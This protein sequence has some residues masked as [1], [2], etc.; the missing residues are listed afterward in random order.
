MTRSAW[1]FVGLLALGAIT[2]S[3]TKQQSSPAAERA[4]E[5][6]AAVSYWMGRARRAEARS[7]ALSA[8]AVAAQER[9]VEARRLLVR[10]PY[11]VEAIRLAS[12]AYHVPFSLLWR[13]ATC[14][15]GPGPN[16]PTPPV[17]ERHVQAHARNPV[18][19]ARSGEHAVGLFAF[20]PSTWR[21]TPYASF[22]IT[23]PYA[24]ALAAAWAQANGR[25]GE[26]ACR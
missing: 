11:S 3:L 20:L 14:E 4:S 7:R 19:E 25:G 13:R 12:V 21:T 5:R 22:P 2:L 26:W 6:T 16:V 9:F 18:A 10:Q 1:P 17:G 8:A 23:S 24:N 15:S